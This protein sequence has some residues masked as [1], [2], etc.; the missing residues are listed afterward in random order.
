MCHYKNEIE[1]EKIESAYY[2]S[3]LEP[4]QG[5]GKL[6]NTKNNVSKKGDDGNELRN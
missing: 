1:K 3:Q 4:N 2:V 6:K 5:K